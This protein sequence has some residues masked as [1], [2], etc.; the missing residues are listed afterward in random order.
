MVFFRLQVL[1]EN[2][3]SPGFFRLPLDMFSSLLAFGAWIES[4]GVDSN[5]VDFSEV[6]PRFRDPLCLQICRQTISCFL[7]LLALFNVQSS[8]FTHRC[9]LASYR[10][11]DSL[12]FFLHH[13]LFPFSFEAAAVMISS[14]DT[15]LRLRF[16]LLPAGRQS[17]L[18]TFLSYFPRSFFSRLPRC[19]RTMVL[20]PYLSSYLD[21]LLTFVPYEV[22]D[23]TSFR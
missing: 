6:L 1:S 16:S 8:F 20:Y 10:G 7:L 3:V 22:E 19:Q 5:S 9:L 2:L 4:L 13:I 21:P 17:V 11:T 14:F 18:L 23:S 15:S 12:F